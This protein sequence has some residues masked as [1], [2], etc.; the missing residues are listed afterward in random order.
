[1][2]C[3]SEQILLLMMNDNGGSKFT[4]IRQIV[5]LKEMLH[6]WHTVTL[7]PR[8]NVHGSE[9]NHTGVPWAI[10]RRLMNVM[11]CDSDEESCPSPEPPPD[12]PRGYLAVY[13]GLELRRFIIPAA[14]LSHPIFKVLLEKAE[15]E[16][17]YDHIGGLTLPCEIETFKYL[18][19]YIENHPTAGDSSK[20]QERVTVPDFISPREP[21]VLLFE[22]GPEF[23]IPC[24]TARTGKL[25]RI[26]S[27]FTGF[28]SRLECRRMR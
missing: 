17:G 15:D 7:G 21:Q 2:S 22:T 5:R 4:R 26:S 1:M 10:N 16:F 27:R 24:R 11:T 23:G 19:Q 28:K 12:V 6:K 25:L 8:K 3:C 20:H 13:V 14:Y 18:M 9:E